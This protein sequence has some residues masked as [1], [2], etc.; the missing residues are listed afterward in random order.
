MMNFIARI[1]QQSDMRTCKQRNKVATDIFRTGGIASCPSQ[2]FIAVFLDLH[3]TS[4]DYETPYK[5]SVA[6]G[7]QISTTEQRTPPLRLCW[8]SFDLPRL[9]AINCTHRMRYALS[10]PLYDLVQAVNCSLIVD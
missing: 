6:D 3:P 8:S 5:L 10:F 2:Y 4:W 7:R 1:P 9:D